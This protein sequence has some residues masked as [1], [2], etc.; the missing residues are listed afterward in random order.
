MASS[1]K[2]K[3]GVRTVEWWK[4]LRWRKKCQQKL[5]RRDGKRQARETDDVQP[6]R[7]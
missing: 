3:G 7:Y 6:V 5:V 2:G 4:H 1:S